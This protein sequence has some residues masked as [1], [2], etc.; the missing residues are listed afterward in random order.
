MKR[1][2]LVGAALGLGGIAA[3]LGC[4]DHGPAKKAEPM[5]KVTA[6]EKA[7]KAPHPYRASLEKSLPTLTIPDETLQRFQAAFERTRPPYQPGSA[8]V[9]LAKL[10]LLSTDFFAKG[11]DESRPLSFVT[12]YGS[13]E[14]PCYN[15]LMNLKS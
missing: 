14:S 1:R 12:L 5:E 15:P 9:Q 3:G 8:D 13:R 11:E 10:F 7:E 2:E 6:P 4:T